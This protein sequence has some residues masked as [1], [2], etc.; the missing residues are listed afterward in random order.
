MLTFCGHARRSFCDGISRRDFFQ[1]GAL[2]L[3]G[4]TLA[5]LLRLRAAGAA[6][7]GASARKS[8]AVIMVIQVGGP[9]HIDTYDM[10]PDAPLEYRG[11]FKPIQ[12][13]VPGVQICE[14]MPMQARIADKLAIVRGLKHTQT[15]STHELHEL[16]T[17]FPTEA[18][19]PAVGS[20][21]SR[22][23]EWNGLPTYVSLRDNLVGISQDSNK[24]TR[25]EDPHYVGAAHRP[26]VPSRRASLVLP[27]G[28]TLDRLADRKELLQSFDSIRRDIDAKGEMASMDAFDARALDMITSDK[29]RDAFDMS[30]EQAKVREKYGPLTQFLQARRL[31]EAGVSVV[32]ILA[33]AEGWD[34]HIRNFEFLRKTLPKVDRAVHALVTDLHERG[35][36]QDVAVV[37]WGEMGRSPRI[38]NG[39]GRDHWSEAAYALLAGGGLQVGQAVGQ[40]DKIAARALGNAYTPQNVLATLYHVLGIDPALT[41][42]DHT[43]RPQHLLEQRDKIAELV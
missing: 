12:T 25:A 7:P 36:H 17:G 28:L 42:P 19:R 11:E 23:R 10:K 27:K 30:R 37:M 34:S 8:K 32:T 3:G 15:Q 33:T 18:K 29:A 35:L 21:V 26:F 22:L 40:S 1:V 43:G 13:N 38:N 5:D 2:G 31:V 16:F 24:L 4:L 41:L 6:G 9:S 14:L 20:I 39:A